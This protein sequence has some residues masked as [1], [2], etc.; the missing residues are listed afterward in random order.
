VVTFTA[1]LA[2][3]VQPDLKED[4]LQERVEL[5][6]PRN[7]AERSEADKLTQDMASDGGAWGSR[8]SG[9]VGKVS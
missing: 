9:W 1:L 6:K 4:E 2:G 8:L 3:H 7:P 5:R